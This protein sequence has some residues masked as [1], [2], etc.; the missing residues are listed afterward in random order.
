MHVRVKICTRS[1]SLTS[2]L[3]NHDQGIETRQVNLRLFQLLIL[4]LETTLAKSFV[5]KRETRYM[6]PAKVYD[7]KSGSNHLVDNNRAR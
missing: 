3:P 4:L 5:C 2:L 6:E 7:M 1:C